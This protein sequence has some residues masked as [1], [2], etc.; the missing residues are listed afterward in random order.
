M[1]EQADLLLH[2]CRAVPEKALT[3]GYEFRSPELETALRSCLQ[4]DH[5]GKMTPL[6]SHSPFF[7]I[8]G[9]AVEDIPE[10]LRDQYLVRPTDNYRVILEGTMDRIWHRPFWLWPL[11]RLLA[12]FD[13][14][15]PEQGSN[16]EASMIIE[17]L[18]DR[19]GG[20]TQM[21]RRTF[22]FRRP[23][24]FDATMAFDLRLGRVVERM[25]PGGVLEVVWNVTFEPPATIRIAT[26]GIRIGMSRYRLA[27]PR[28]ATVQVQV[29][30]TALEDR[31]DT[32]AV[33]L[34]VRQ[35]WLGEIFGYDGRFQVHREIWSDA[36]KNDSKS[37]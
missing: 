6:G 8:L 14:L 5:S 37:L 11:F 26:E 4:R 2:G 12:F 36:R 32:I 29:S 20:S 30:E 33:D 15:F 27:L 31:S 22:R 17:G 34:A 13:I 18:H 1:G 7:P 28:W 24:R 3:H 9:G 21:W 23:R 16:I 10:V 19:Q 25:R 35:R